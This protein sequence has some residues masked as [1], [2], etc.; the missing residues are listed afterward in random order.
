[1]NVSWRK[2]LFVVINKHLHIIFLK[3]ILYNLWLK[4]FHIT[5]IKKLI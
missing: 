5:I 4:Q 3:T 1:M 2:L